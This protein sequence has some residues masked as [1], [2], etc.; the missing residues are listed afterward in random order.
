MLLQLSGGADQCGHVVP[1]HLRHHG[2]AGWIFGDR[3]QDKAL[4]ARLTVHAEIFGPVHVRTAVPGHQ[5]PERQVRNV[6]HRRQRK[7]RLTAFQP[8]IHHFRYPN[9]NGRVPQIRTLELGDSL[10]LGY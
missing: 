1:D 8:R 3:S 2:A 5:M 9:R 10:V 4:Q 7:D 6:L